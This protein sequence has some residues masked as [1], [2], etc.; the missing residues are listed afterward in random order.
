VTITMTGDR[1]DLVA[2]QTAC[3]RQQTNIIAVLK[4]EIATLHAEVDRLNGLLGGSADAVATLQQLYSSPDS[5]PSV[6][7]RA[8]GLAAP[9]ERAKAP[10]VSHLYVDAF[11]ERLRLAR[12]GQVVDVTPD[13]EADTAD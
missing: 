10:H 7:L 4:N 11:A 6:R 2:R 8:A 1:D 13:D 5:P 3:I 12:L 9:F